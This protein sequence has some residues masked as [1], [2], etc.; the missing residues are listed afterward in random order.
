MERKRWK[1][2][3]RPVWQLNCHIGWT[4]SPQSH[5]HIHANPRPLYE[6]SASYCIWSHCAAY[7]DRLNQAISWINLIFQCVFQSC[8]RRPHRM[9]FS[10]YGKVGQLKIVNEKEQKKR[11]LNTELSKIP[12]ENSLIFSCKLQFMCQKNCLPS[13]SYSCHIVNLK[14]AICG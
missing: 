13:F 7:I 10:Q 11:H 9:V 4:S 8:I 5:T 12:F 2:K 6:S 14:W 3:R 1:K